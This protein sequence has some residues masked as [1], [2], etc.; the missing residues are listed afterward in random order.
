MRG[1]LSDAYCL[2]LDEERILIEY[3]GCGAI[4]QTE[5][6]E[7]IWVDLPDTV[8][9]Q[10]DDDRKCVYVITRDGLVVRMNILTG[11][12]E[13]ICKN[14]LFMY[15]D[16][17][18]IFNGRVFFGSRNR[19]FE[20]DIEFRDIRVIGY[21]DQADADTIGAYR[22]VRRLSVGGRYAVMDS[23]I[24]VNISDGEVVKQWWNSNDTRMPD[25]L[26]SLN[27]R[28]GSIHI[29]VLDPVRKVLYQ[30]ESINNT[31]IQCKG[32]SFIELDEQK[33]VAIY[34]D[35][36]RMLLIICGEKQ[37]QYY[38]L[39]TGK[40]SKRIPEFVFEQALMQTMKCDR[41]RLEEAVFAPGGNGLEVKV[42]C[43]WKDKMKL[44][45][46]DQFVFI[47]CENRCCIVHGEEESERTV[48]RYAF[49]SEDILTG[50]DRGRRIPVFEENPEM[51]T[52]RQ[53]LLHYYD[54]YQWINGFRTPDGRLDKCLAFFEKILMYFDPENWNR[55]RKM[56]N[57]SIKLFEHG[58]NYCAM[59]EGGFYYWDDKKRKKYPIYVR[60][61]DQ[62]DLEL[63]LAGG[64]YQV[65]PIDN[66][67]MYI[68]GTNAIRYVENQERNLMECQ[69]QSLSYQPECFLFGCPG[70]ESI[71]LQQSK[72][73]RRVFDEY[74]S[75]ADDEW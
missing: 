38:D 30:Y 59:G 75:F 43:S 3:D 48:L 29:G 19:L 44:Y 12:L 16:R 70:A 72:R 53:E 23:R 55:N 9:G 58:A 6:E 36:K 67:F 18:Q 54:S 49:P 13:Q 45:T 35:F 62:V 74:E 69:V 57:I 40:K 11:E 46:K 27:P 28:L 51:E 39:N 20:T 7:T 8:L 33:I 10:V 64:D 63:K 1:A 65:Y 26:L 52:K 71:E 37:I 32:Y 50:A 42:A 34:A 24:M 73:R 22:P 68:E 60:R 31:P 14:N 17:M 41:C 15:I 21:F 47:D 25:T 5:T 66:G 4:Y 2:I 56:H 61:F